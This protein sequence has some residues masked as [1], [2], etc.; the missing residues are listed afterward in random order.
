[1]KKIKKRKKL[2]ANQFS[3]PAPTEIRTMIK[4]K[5][6]SRNARKKMPDTPLKCSLNSKDMKIQKK[7][8]N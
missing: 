1:M 7:K 5:L 8:M 6:N 4:I 2:Y 3:L